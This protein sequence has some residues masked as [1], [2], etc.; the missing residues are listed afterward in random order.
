MH[1]ACYRDYWDF[2]YDAH[3][4]KRLSLTLK[5]PPPIKATPPPAPVTTHHPAT[6][7]HTWYS[8]GALLDYF[9]KK[10]GGS[11][12]S[13]AARIHA[14]PK[15]PR[16][17]HKRIDYHAAAASLFQKENHDTMILATLFR[18]SKVDAP[19]LPQGIVTM[20]L[21]Y[22][23]VDAI[24][25]KFEDFHGFKRPKK[26]YP[27]PPRIKAII[28]GSSLTHPSGSFDASNPLF[29]IQRPP[30]THPRSRPNLPSKMP[31]RTSQINE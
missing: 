8:G 7:Q 18:K 26:A 31:G 27:L 14:A 21:Q 30:Y 5:A 16:V 29:F 17:T 19:C 22:L 25:L 3:L 28:L 9:K 2:A 4:N 24:I 20:L 10:W 15:V 11:P 6:D 23:A 12:S 1:A 13:Q